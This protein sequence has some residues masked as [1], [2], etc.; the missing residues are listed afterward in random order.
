MYGN[1][2]KDWFYFTRHQRLGIIVL[3]SLLAVMPIAG[4]ITERLLKHRSLDEQHFAVMIEEYQKHLASIE[5]AMARLDEAAE[6]EIAVRAYNLSEEQ[7]ITPVPFDPNVLTLEEWTSMG[8][9]SR[10]ARTISN[11]LAA[12]GGFTYKQDLQRIYIM[13]DETYAALED[14]IE[15]PD[16]NTAESLSSER[17]A[18]MTSEEQTAGSTKRTPTTNDTLL[19]AARYYDAS[20]ETRHS[21][22]EISD[23]QQ[24]YM[25]SLSGA[26]PVMIHLNRADSTT[27][28]SIRGIGPVFSRRIVRYRELLGGYHCSSQLL[29]VFG[30]DSLRYHDIAGYVET[31]TLDI[32]KIN[33]NE[34][35]FTDLVSHPYIEQAVASAILNLRRQHGPFAHPED[36]KNSYL[37]D[38]QLWKRLK[39][40]LT[41]SNADP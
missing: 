13:D 30:M 1:P 9:S 39:P 23:R 40:Y 32:R 25:E 17:G 19:Y 38:D 21:H 12:G 26:E 3:L 29:E 18:A 36:I 31:D 6:K 11:Y 15:L 20:V 10:L 4:W 2:V 14:Y 16:R 33:V 34:A 28:Q 41:A 5:E 7:K 8:V 37:V 27:F 24:T 22:H 35:S